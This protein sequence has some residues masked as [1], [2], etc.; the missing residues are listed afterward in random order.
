MKHHLRALVCPLAV[1]IGVAFISR[2]DG[3]T[4]ASGQGGFPL[5]DSITSMWGAV[6]EPVSSDRPK[7]LTFMIYF[8]GKPGWHQGKW[9]FSSNMNENPAFI[10]FSGPVVLRAEFDRGTKTLRV[11]G[12]EFAIAETNVVVVENIDEPDRRKFTGLGHVDL[13]PSADANPALYVLEHYEGIRSAV[14]PSAE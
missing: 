10:E 8:V 11:L 6:D 13:N 1:L 9:S 12:T 3:P 5:T 7:P 2:A 14:L 4:R